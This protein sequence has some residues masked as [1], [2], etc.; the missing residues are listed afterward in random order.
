MKTL[1]VYYK[2]YVYI[3]T[4]EVEWISVS[5]KCV[6]FVTVSDDQTLVYKIDGNNHSIFPYEIQYGSCTYFVHNTI[7]GDCS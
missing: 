2:S 5:V 3:F 4:L 1:L 6:N 7:Q